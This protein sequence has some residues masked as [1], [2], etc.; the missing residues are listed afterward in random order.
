[1]PFDRI[2]FLCFLFVF[3]H[4]LIFILVSS[5][6]EKGMTE[7][8]RGLGR[9]GGTIERQTEREREGEGGACVLCV[10]FVVVFVTQKERWISG[11][12]RGGK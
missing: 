11:V 12:G 8:E 1:M 9:K 4:F 7:R 2:V 6:F 3:S 10:L 5:D